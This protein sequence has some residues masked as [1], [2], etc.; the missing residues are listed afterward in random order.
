MS[1]RPY[2]KPGLVSAL[3]SESGSGSWEIGRWDSHALQVR[4]ERYHSRTVSAV[5]TSAASAS[6]RPGRL[7]QVPCPLGPRTPGARGRP[8]RS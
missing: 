3:P 8:A 1:R 6:R 2:Q 5:G 7:H 4:R